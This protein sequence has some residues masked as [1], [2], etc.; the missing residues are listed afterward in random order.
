MTLEWKPVDIPFGQG[1]DQKS[2]ALQIPVGKLSSLVN[3]RILKTGQITKRTGFTALTSTAFNTSGGAATILQYLRIA[4]LDNQLLAFTGDKAYSWSE[5][6]SAWSEIGGCTQVE[7]SANF[8]A[9][10]SGLVYDVDVAYMAGVEGYVYKLGL[11]SVRY[12]AV[13]SVTRAV[14]ASFEVSSSGDSPKIVAFGS[15]FLV[16]FQ[17]SS[18]HAMMYLLQPPMSGVFAGVHAVPGGASYTRSVYDACVIG[19]NLFLCWGNYSAGAG[20]CHVAKFNASMTQLALW[21]SASGVTGSTLAAVSCWSMPAAGLLGVAYSGGGNLY[22]GSLNLDTTSH[23]WAVTKATTDS[24]ARLAGTPSVSS[25][26]TAA[27]V[28]AEEVDSVLAAHRVYRYVAEVAGGGLAVTE[29]LTAPLM[30]ICGKPFAYLGHIVLPVVCGAPASGLVNPDMTNGFLGLLVTDTGSVVARCGYEKTATLKTSATCAETAFAGVDPIL[31]N[32]ETDGVTIRTCCISSYRF[33]LSDSATYRSA[34]LGSELFVGGSVPQC[35]DGR[36]MV[37]SGFVEVPHIVSDT[38]VSGTVPAGSYAWCFTYRWTDA[39]GVV[40]ESAPSLPLFKTTTSPQGVSFVVGTVTAT[41]KSGVEIVGY[42]TQDLTTAGDSTYYRFTSSSAPVLNDKTVTSKIVTDDNG[43]FSTENEVLYTTGGVL[44]NNAPRGTK[45]PVA[46]KGRIWAIDD[47]GHTLW[48]SKV[49]QAGHPVEWND[50]LCAPVDDRFGPAIALGVL[51]DHLVI[52]TET[53]VYHFVGEGPDNTGANNDYG[54]PQLVTTD[55]GCTYADSVVQTPVGLMFQSRKGV[56]LLDRSFS[57]KFLGAPVEDLLGSSVKP[58]GTLRRDSNEVV[59]M[60]GASGAVVYNYYFDQWYSWLLPG[61]YGYEAFDVGSGFYFRGSSCVYREQDAGVLSYADDGVATTLSLTTGWLPFSGLQGFQKV[62]DALLLVKSMGA[63][64]TISV[65]VGYDYDEVTWTTA[66]VF[67]SNQLFRTDVQTAAV[68]NLLDPAWVKATGASASNYDTVVSSGLSNP[69]VA[70]G[71]PIALLL[72]AVYSLDVKG[73]G[74]VYWGTGPEY[75][76]FNAGTGAV[77][78]SSGC[79]GFS[80][81]SL[82]DGW[83]RAVMTISSPSYASLGFGPSSAGSC[84]FRNP[85]I[86]QMTSALAAEQIRIWLTKQ[87]C[88]SLRLHI[89]VTP[90]T[91]YERYNPCT[92]SGLTFTV[93]TEKGHNRIRPERRLAT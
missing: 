32:A 10:E 54:L 7:S 56:Y 36:G 66:A 23:A 82:G 69:S 77:S 70:Q 50:S 84:R 39:R 5:A 18:S 63:D 22:I 81:T 33:V 6:R 29:T 42:R 59:F 53:A 24:V 57:V 79:S 37:E 38:N 25:P 44:E 67:D 85:S 93:G 43:S 9:G 46:W 45:S 35:Y 47:T 51:D 1:I 3:G 89:E 4:G 78:T 71:V 74:S 86:Q 87:R 8:I 49:A 26:S 62:R 17:D 90:K 21:D 68:N 80:Y 34:Q 28:F 20:Y 30:G 60:A 52:F 64:H 76:V 65:R 16:L 72:P 41:I 12:V 83:Y 92:L 15:N 2:D 91:G 13:D 40:H 75:V 73:S 58:C 55:V 11:Q 88:E 14:L 61:S 27:V 19:G 31:V 48:Y